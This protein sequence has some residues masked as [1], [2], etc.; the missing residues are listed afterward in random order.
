[1]LFGRGIVLTSEDFG[2]QGSPPTHPELLD[3][4]AAEFRD[5]GLESE[6]DATSDR[7]LDNLQAVFPRNVRR[8]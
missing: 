6:G 1:M 2:A 3:Y 4:L 7:H 8:S 5:G